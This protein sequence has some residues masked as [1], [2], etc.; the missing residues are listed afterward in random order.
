MTKRPLYFK[1]KLIICQ[2]NCS[3]EIKISREL[4]YRSRENLDIDNDYILQT[5][6]KSNYSMM[7]GIYADINSKCDHWI[8]IEIDFYQ[9]LFSHYSY[10]I[11]SKVFN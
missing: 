1:Y 9:N 4:S 6:M 8:N 2:L 7:K 3:T 11:L 10:E 5:L